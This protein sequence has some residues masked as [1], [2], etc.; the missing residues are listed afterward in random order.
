MTVTRIEKSNPKYSRKNTLTLTLH[1]DNLNRRQDVSVYNPHSQG[2]NLPIIILLHGVYG[3]NWVWMDSGGA[4]IVYENLRKQGISEFVLVMPSDGGIWEGSAYLPLEDEGNFEQW[5]MEDVINTVIDTVDSVSKSSNLYI[6]GLSMGGYGALR[7]GAKF[8]KRFSG[9][10]AHSSI[11]QI[12]DLAIFTD[13]PLNQYHTVDPNEPDILF[14]CEKN[15]NYMPPLRLDCG[16]DDELIQS[17]RNLVEKLTLANIRHQYQEMKGGHEW[18]YWHNN[19]AK[20]L[21]FFNHIEIKN[22]T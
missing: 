5:I 21:E 15:K 22:K 4:H 7:L 14:W 16:T 2:K 9:I 17:N 19:L 18:S 6:T 12:Q 8:A 20:T 3:N 1:S 10:S 11:T 13:T